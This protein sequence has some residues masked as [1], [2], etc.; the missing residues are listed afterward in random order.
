LGSITLIHPAE[1]GG[2]L[3]PLGKGGVGRWK[4]DIAKHC[5]EPLNTEPHFILSVNLRRQVVSVSSFNYEEMEA[6]Q[7]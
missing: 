7:G 2:D 1:G 3:F 5:A 6:K 4:S